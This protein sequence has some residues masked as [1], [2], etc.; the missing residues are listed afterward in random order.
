MTQV[1]FLFC[2]TSQSINATLLMLSIVEKGKLHR[3]SGIW[4]Q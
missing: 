2:N 3:E 1:G 4:R